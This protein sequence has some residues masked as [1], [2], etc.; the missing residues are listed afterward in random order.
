MIPYKDNGHLTQ[1]E[2]HYNK[3]L[4]STR[5][6]VE[7]AIGMF[8]GRWRYLADKLPMR[9]TDLIPYYIISCCVL[10]NI[11]LLQNDEFEY[12]VV[13]NDDIDVEPRPMAVNQ[14]LQNNGSIKRE[15]IKNTLNI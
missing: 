2:K 10:H 11:C 5:M 8:K 6:I 12:P 9:R 3:L 7:R 15:K 13:I 4:S 1:E 14:L